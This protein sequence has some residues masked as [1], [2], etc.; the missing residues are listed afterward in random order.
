M[1]RKGLTRLSDIALGAGL[2][3]LFG[4][5]GLVGALLFDRGF[6]ELPQFGLPRVVVGWIEGLFPGGPAGICAGAVHQAAQLLLPGLGGDEPLGNVLAAEKLK[7][8]RRHERVA[9]D[10]ERRCASPD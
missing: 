2:A 1:T 8:C 9:D 6:T 7:F 5:A 3:R 10:V 4:L